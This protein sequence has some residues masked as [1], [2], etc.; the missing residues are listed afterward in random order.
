VGDAQSC[1][2]AKTFLSMAALGSAALGWAELWFAA[3]HDAGNYVNGGVLAAWIFVAYALW[4]VPLG[5]AGTAPVR[6]LMIVASFLG[7]WALLKAV[8]EPWRLWH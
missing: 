3:V 1:Y 4:R 7:Q 8:E 5:A 6:L 2:R